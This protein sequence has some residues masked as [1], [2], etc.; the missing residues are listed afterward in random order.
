MFSAQGTVHKTRV[1][2]QSSSLQGGCLICLFVTSNIMSDGVKYLNSSKCHS[3]RY[4]ISKASGI[5]NNDYLVSFGNN[6]SEASVQWL[7]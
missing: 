1:Q 7:F 2:W 4:K 6:F 5:S 3:I